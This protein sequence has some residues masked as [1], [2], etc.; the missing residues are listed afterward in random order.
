MNFFTKLIGLIV[1]TLNV[2]GCDNVSSL[3]FSGYTNG[4]FIYLSHNNTEKIDKILVQKGSVVK[5]G[6]T[7]VLMEGFSSEN[8]LNVT[9]KSYQA[10][11]AL[12]R[13]MESGE[14]PEE[15][16]IIRSQLERAKS[17][18][19]LAKIHMDRNRA[20]YTTEVISKL[21]WE[22]IREDYVQKTAQVNEL[23]HQLKARGLPARKEQIKNQQ[24]RVDSAKLQL[25]KARWNQQQN[26]IVA[27]Q[28]GLIFD[29][30]YRVGERPIAGNP[31]ISLLPPQNIKVRF[32][33]PE[34]KLNSVAINKKV[35]LSCDECPKNLTGHINYISAQAEYSPPMIYSTRRREKLLF[36]A[37]AVPDEKHAL[38]VKLGQ[39]IE[40]RLASNE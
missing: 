38:S 24:L 23:N 30:I 22:T 26:I 11:L 36:M 4:D 3:G 25:E 2:G 13:N 5:K 6:Q 18:A 1:V 29:I 40:V 33:V 20:L 7:L 37:E 8:S 17:A 39:P 14:R 32:F 27:P 10:E 15:L 34:N 28:D 35:I 19:S 16:A 21:D 9:E 31:I 12:L